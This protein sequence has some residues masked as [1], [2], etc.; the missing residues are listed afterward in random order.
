MPLALLRLRQDGIQFKT[1]PILEMIQEFQR[2][3]IRTSILLIQLDMIEGAK[4]R[5]IELNCTLKPL[6]INTVW[7]IKSYR[8]LYRSSSFS[9][10][11]GFRC[12]CRP[13]FEFRYQFLNKHSRFTWSFYRT[14][15]HYRVAVSRTGKRSQYVFA[16]LK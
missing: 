5:Y 15:S 4:N 10:R 12:Q 3:G 13:R 8:T 9:K 14:R 7:V 1:K 16:K 6:R 11:L 2:N